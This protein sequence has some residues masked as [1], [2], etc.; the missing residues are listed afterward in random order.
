MTNNKNTDIVV[1]AHGLTKHFGNL[2]A[3]DSLSLNIKRGEIYGFLG[4]NGAG[5]TTTI[6]MLLGMV[7]P[8]SGT[9]E[10]FGQNVQA[11]SHGIWARVGYMVDIPSAYPDLTVRQNLE[12]TRRLYHVDR[13]MQELAI[14]TYADRVARTLSH[15]NAQ[16]LGLAK[17]MLHEPELLLL[18]EPASGLDPAGIVEVRERL[19]ALAHERG[20][21]VLMSSHILDEVARL[22]S[23]IGII[24]Q[25]A[26]LEELDAPQLEQQLKPHLVVDACDREAAKLA[27]IKNGFSINVGEDGT[28]QVEGESAIEHPDEIANLLV[29]EDVPPTLLQV[30]QESL[31]THFLKLVE[32]SKG[33]ET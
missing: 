22:A 21:T 29:R 10:I 17:A 30:K 33:K 16:R 2:T 27:L 11:V 18:D 3:V 28:L 23:R 4:L 8:T 6:R 25:G 26:L 7:R 24:H 13:I 12:I 14:H 5:K 9:A 1:S 19:R 31:E 32:S 20:T 15:G